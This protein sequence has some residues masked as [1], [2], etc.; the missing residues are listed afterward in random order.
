[1]FYFPQQANSIDMDFDL[2]MD[3]PIPHGIYSCVNMLHWYILC[4][5]I[6]YYIKHSHISFIV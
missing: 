6:P 1:M 5:P 3:T 2:K 4:K